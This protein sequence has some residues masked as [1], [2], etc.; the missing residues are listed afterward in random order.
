MYP[1]ELASVVLQISQEEG[2]I[3]LQSNGKSDQEM[4]QYT[5]QIKEGKSQPVD[6][7]LG[8]IRCDQLCL[9]ILHP[10]AQL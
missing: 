2:S 7:L 9:C 10:I 1:T 4:T 6:A 5:L 8:L 3:Y